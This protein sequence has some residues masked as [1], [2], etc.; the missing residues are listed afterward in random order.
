[1]NIEKELHSLEKRLEKIKKIHKVLEAT[2]EKLVN[3]KEDLAGVIGYDLNR[4]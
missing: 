3:S 1:M 2:I 4:R